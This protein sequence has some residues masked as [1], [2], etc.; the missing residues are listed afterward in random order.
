M[1]T[2][3]FFLTIVSNKTLPYLG[4]DAVNQV[5]CFLSYLYVDL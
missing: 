3:V 1:V 5:F 4:T 2:I